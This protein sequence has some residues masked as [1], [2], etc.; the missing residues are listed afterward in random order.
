MFRHI[1]LGLAQE[2]N[3]LL[4]ITSHHYSHHSWAGF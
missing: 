4:Q 1:A 3:L 2:W